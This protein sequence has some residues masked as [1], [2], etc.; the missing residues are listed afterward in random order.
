M[1][2]YGLEAGAEKKRK[3]IEK[4]NIYKLTLKIRIHNSVT[5]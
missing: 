2:R 3:K 4:R 1:G 5:P